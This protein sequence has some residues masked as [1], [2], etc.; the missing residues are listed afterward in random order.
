MECKHHE[1]E[2]IQVRR[3][4]AFRITETGY[5]INIEDDN[6]TENR[7]HIGLEYLP[8]IVGILAEIMNDNTTDIPCPKCD[9]KT[10]SIKPTVNTIGYTCIDCGHYFIVEVPNEE[11]VI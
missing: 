6:D 5:S 7:V 3:E 10:V 1:I 11:N 2:I 8:A 4:V 9:S